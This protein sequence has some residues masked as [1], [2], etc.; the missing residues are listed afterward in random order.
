VLAINDRSWE[1]YLAG[2]SSNFRQQVRR[3]E[4]RLYDR[5]DVTVRLADERTFGDDME[6]LFALHAARWR[7]G[8]SAAF[9]GSR[10]AFHRE[11][12]SLALARGWLR[13]WILE[14][15]GRP[16]AAWYG[17][18]FGG[19]EWYYQSGRDPA[20]DTESVGFVLMSHTIRAAMQDG[21]SEYRF[22]LG[23]ERYKGR[24]A[25]DDRG[26]VTVLAPTRPLGSVALRA[27]LAR[28]SVRRAAKW[29]LGSPPRA[30]ASAT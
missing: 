16:A 1:E 29:L 18:R 4:R 10:K 3:R 19:S 17:F 11:F 5:Y 25:S 7:D 22:L 15:D 20:L 30:A 27:A 26:E 23:D 9:A 14:L 8:G 12:A 13:L 28:R 21:M 6:T 24:F 2:Q